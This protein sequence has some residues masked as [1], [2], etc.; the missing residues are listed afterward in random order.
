MDGLPF[1]K[2]HGLGNDFVVLDAREQAVTVHP[3]QARRIA[4]RHRGVGFDQL[5][6]IEPAQ[7]AGADVFMR[8][9]NADGTESGACGNGTRCVAALV[10][11]DTG[12]EALVVETR[13]GLLECSKA[14]E[15]GVTV[16]MGPAR[17]GWQDIPLAHEADTLHLPVSSGLLTDG[18]GVSMGNP[19]AVFFVP[20]AEKVQIDGVGPVL[21]HD[22]LF[23][24]RANIGVVQV[25]GRDRLRYRVWERGVGVTQACGSGACA[26]GVAAVRRGLTDRTV[27]VDLDGGT[28]L[29]EWRESDGHV[30][31][32]GP[33]ETSFAGILARGLLDG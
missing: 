19:H 3:D 24:E 16:D 8:I 13:G 28:L 18:V 12:A 27:W 30:L 31:M 5:L 26:A 6:V 14:P 7:S 11:A 20:E 17:L 32:T 29:I 9:L 22:P 21:E 23:P 4:D 15:G 1:W 25:L 2:M 33:A 10:M